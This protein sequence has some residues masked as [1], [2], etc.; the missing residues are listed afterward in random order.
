MSSASGRSGQWLLQAC[1]AWT[2]IR[3]S[4]LK[5]FESL[6]YLRLDLLAPKLRLAI[7]D[8]AEARIS[9][10][11]TSMSEDNMLGEISL[12]SQLDLTWDSLGSNLQ[13]IVQMVAVEK[14]WKV[15][16][17]CTTSLASP[18]YKWFQGA[19]AVSCKAYP[20]SEQ[21]LGKMVFYCQAAHRNLWTSMP[22][23]LLLWSYLSFPKPRRDWERQK[24]LRTFGAST[25]TNTHLFVLFQSDEG[26]PNPTI[27]H[28]KYTCESCELQ[29]STQLNS[30]GVCYFRFTL[31]KSAVCV[32]V[33][34][35]S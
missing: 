4:C 23:L 18:L 29:W 2:H 3:E 7:D 27:N 22:M 5:M 8:T 28:D 19:I 11:A 14:L 35:I 12:K 31:R 33:I 15:G 17:V 16:L 9:A 1:S 10:L 34:L 24:Q 13:F 30:L 26:P 21:T 25:N 32:D 6:R 20:C